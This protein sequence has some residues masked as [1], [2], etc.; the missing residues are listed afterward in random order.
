MSALAQ[1]LQEGLRELELTWAAEEQ[2]EIELTQAERHAR[3]P[4]GWLNS[5]HVWIAS[6]FDTAGK[7][8]AGR[9]LRPVKL[10]LFPTQQQLI[11]A[12][13]DLPHLA[14]TGELVFRNVVDEK[15]RQIGETWAVAGIICWALHYHRVTGLAINRDGARIDDGGE[16]STVDSL[17]GRIRY[18][19]QRLDRGKLPGLAAKLI[20]RPFSRDP[21]KIEN[22]VRGSFVVGEGQSDDPG[23][24]STYDFV[25]GDEFAFLLH[26]ER[27]H[28]ALDEA[29]PDGKLYLST[30]NGDGNAH[31]RLAKERPA[32]WTYLRQHWSQHPVYS[33]GLHV[34]GADPAC[35]LCEG[36][37]AEVPWNPSDPRAHRY[38]GKPTSPWYDLRVI[39]KTDEQVANELDIDRERAKAGRVYPEFRT[40][41]H[42]VESGIPYDPRLELELAADY[43]LDATSIIVLQDAPGELRAIGLLETGHLFGTSGTPDATSAA[44][45]DYLRGLG[46]EERLLEHQWTRRLYAVGDPSGHNATMETGRPFVAAYRRHGF[47]FGK[48]PSRLTARITPSITA[49]KLLLDGVPKPLRVCG[50]NAAAFAEHARENTW[51]VGPDGRLL[52]LNDDIHNH[53]MR[54]AG[55]YAVAKFPPQGEDRAGGDLLE[56]REHV[57]S[58]L[59]RRRDRAVAGGM[60]AA[61]LAFDSAL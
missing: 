28:A 11:H 21:A 55:Y 54:A 23:R 39:G 42:V 9:K 32:G 16:R 52:G 34:A 10:T 35:E 49:L 41:I 61:P 20:F 60:D 24:G 47:Y 36:S 26:S 50:V 44:L 19:D 14:R 48:P 33:V 6:R 12:W 8:L 13:L 29:C 17:F 3:D 46:V 22:P 45:R 18:I 40:D 57:P 59:E 1:A 25:A 5:G 4:V 30:V 31:A 43:G 58:A 53:A 56:Q 27:V 2:Q 38:P 15:S 51:R 37:R 7:E